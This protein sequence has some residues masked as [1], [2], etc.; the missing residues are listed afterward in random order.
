MGKTFTV[1]VR[2]KIAAAEYTEPYVCDNSDYEIEF[3]FSEEWQAFELKTARFA[4]GGKTQDVI[5]EGSRC[6]VPRMSGICSFKVGAFAGDL[7]TTTPAYIE[8]RASILSEGGTPA[9]PAPDVYDQLMQRM[10]EIEAP[11]AVL[12]TKQSLTDEQKAQARKNIDAA[13]DNGVI[14]LNSP[15]TSTK[16]VQAIIKNPKSIIQSMF[17][18]IGSLN[19]G[20]M[21]FLPYYQHYRGSGYQ[22]Y[23]GYAIGNYDVQNS[24][25]VPFDIYKYDATNDMGSFRVQLTP[26][27]ANKS[28]LDSITGIVTAD[29]LT[30]PDHSTDLV[31]YE[32]FQAAVPLVQQM[33][34]SGATVGQTIKVKTVD[35]N[36]RPT[37][38]E[39]ADMASGNSGRAWI[40][41]CD[42]TLTDDDPNVSK[43]EVTTLPDGTPL[44][45]LG[46][47]DIIF[48]LS[49]KIAEASSYSYGTF[50]INDKSIVVGQNFNVKTADENWYRGRFYFLGGGYASAEWAASSGSGPSLLGGGIIIDPNGNGTNKPGVA[51]RYTDSE[52]KKVIVTSPVATSG[53]TD[54]FKSGRLVIFGR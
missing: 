46:I 21:T 28:I 23:L 34:I 7:S 47:T 17:T 11:E 13:K 2:G 3:D 12:Y 37:S 4:Y 32:A 44:E 15:V 42:I 9:A 22:K 30:S 10:N 27:H 18:G 35:A 50:L 25:D 33:N 24:K 26:M 31:A 53:A 38:W 48:A 45:G 54:N 41:I 5:F 14:Y 51:D 16:I 29:K 36:G 6:A 20:R 8:A 39:A 19:G 43:I 49:E 52:I 1:K 40:K